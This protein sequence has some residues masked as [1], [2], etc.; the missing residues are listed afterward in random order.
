MADCT[1]SLLNVHR[2]WTAIDW[3]VK[4]CK[5]NN[6][7]SQTKNSSRKHLSVFINAFRIINFH[8]VEWC[9]QA[10]CSKPNN[11]STKNQSTTLLNILATFVD[12]WIHYFI[13]KRGIWQSGGVF[14][15]NFGP[16]GVGIWTS[17]SSKEGGGGM[18]ADV[19]NWLAHWFSEVKSLIY[20]LLMSHVYLAFPSPFASLQSSIYCIIL[21]TCMMSI[22][23]GIDRLQYIKI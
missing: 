18:D 23:L 13:F 4:Y 21:H 5:M 15:C 11:S 22:I 9:L 17:Q 20:C 8:L 2:A 3:K 16:G 14:K 6:N 7:L 19:L 12:H 1:A 10:I